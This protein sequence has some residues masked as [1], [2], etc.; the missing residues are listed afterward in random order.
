MILQECILFCSVT[1]NKC[2]H[3][4]DNDLHVARVVCDGVV[5]VEDVQVGVV[6]GGSCTGE[7][8]LFTTN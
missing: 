6:R 7:S 8:F 5:R 2:Y 3:M 1:Q 4:E